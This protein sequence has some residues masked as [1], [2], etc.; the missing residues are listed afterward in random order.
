MNNFYNYLKLLIFKYAKKILYFI[1]NFI[2]LTYA[3]FFS[4]YFFKKYEFKAM[5]INYNKLDHI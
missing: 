3:N 2:N 1:L 4:T 5:Q